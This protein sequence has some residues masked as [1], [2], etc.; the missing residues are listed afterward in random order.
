MFGKV[1]TNK[2]KTPVMPDSS[3][4]N[5]DHTAEDELSVGGRG[6]PLEHPDVS[7][8]SDRQVSHRQWTPADR[9][10]AQERNSSLGRR[11]SWNAR[12]QIKRAC[13]DRAMEHGAATETW[14][15][16]ACYLCI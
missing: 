16:D 13:E 14:Y 3:L 8:N 11:V 15:L 2:L 1:E 5:R 10:K 6:A 7:G 12:E 9:R 4:E